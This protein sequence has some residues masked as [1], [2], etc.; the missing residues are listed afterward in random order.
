MTS[1][2]IYRREDIPSLICAMEAACCG[3]E[4][5]HHRA[6]AVEQA[7]DTESELRLLHSSCMCLIPARVIYFGVDGEIAEFIRVVIQ[8]MQF[9]GCHHQR[10]G[11][12]D[13]V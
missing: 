8:A 4:Y 5:Q 7:P 9:G 2:T 3:P 1:E 11:A 6:M 10:K 12:M 13:T